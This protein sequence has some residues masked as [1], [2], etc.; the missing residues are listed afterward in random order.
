MK[1]ATIDYNGKAYNIKQSFRA[2]I[3]FEKI[4]GRNAYEASTSITDSITILYAMLRVCNTDFILTHD[5]FLDGLDENPNALN[6][7]N[8]YIIALA[9]DALELVKIS[10]TSKKKAVKPKH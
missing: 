9:K 10:E 6:Q 4:T 5:E 7:F 1:T 2:L 3:E 8:E